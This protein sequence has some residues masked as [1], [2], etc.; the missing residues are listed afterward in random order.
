V[1]EGF[2]SI[3]AQDQLKLD[4]EQLMQRPAETLERVAEFIGADV[5][6]EVRLEALS[7]RPRNERTVDDETWAEIQVALAP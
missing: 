1:A 6:D 3:P 4:Y 2:E 5:V 7:L